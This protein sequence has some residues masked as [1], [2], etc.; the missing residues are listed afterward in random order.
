MGSSSLGPW[1]AA[2][3]GS[4]MCPGSKD[5]QQPPGLHKVTSSRLR[6]WTIL[7]YSAL[8]RPCLTVS[9]FGPFKERHKVDPQQRVP[10]MVKA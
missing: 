1:W 8:V 7:P 10:T 2:E 5:G 6:E 9:G 3:H 4:A